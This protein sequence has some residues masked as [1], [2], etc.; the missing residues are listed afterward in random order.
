MSNRF[1]NSHTFSQMANEYMV[2]LK[3]FMKLSK[4]YVKSLITIVKLLTLSNYFA[5]LSIIHNQ[6]HFFVHNVKFVNQYRMCQNQLLL[7]QKKLQK[8]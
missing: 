1:A 3:I 6:R 8:R 7:C 5:Q 4:L 2:I